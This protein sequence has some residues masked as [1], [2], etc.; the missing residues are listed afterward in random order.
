MDENERNKTERK[1]GE[2]KIQLIKRKEV[3]RIKEKCK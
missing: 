3:L 1:Q 2:S